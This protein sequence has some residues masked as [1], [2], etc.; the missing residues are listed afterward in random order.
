MT[1]ALVLQP[2]DAQ[3]MLRDSAVRWVADAV[4]ARSSAAQ[5]W[6]AMAELGWLG[7][8]VPEAHGGL[9]EGL[10]ELCIVAEALGRGP[11]P[12]PFGPVAVTAAG[13]LAEGGDAAQRARW[14]PA[15]AAGEARVAPAALEPAGA[16]AVR[17][18]REAGGWRLDGIK[19]PVPGGD[20]ADAWLVVA[21]AGPAAAGS[22][23]ADA[24]P[25]GEAAVFVVLPG[26][27]GVQA[28]PFATVDGA[29]AVELRLDAVRVPDDARLPNAD[30][31][32]IARLADRERVV[33]CAESVGAIDALLEATVAY[34]RTRVQFGRPLAANQALR[35]RLA[36]LAVAAEEAR[37]ITLGAVLALQGAAA[38]APRTVAGACAKVFGAARR[39]AE[40]A[41]Q[42]HGGMG[43]T[44]EL[45][46][47]AYLKRQLA[48]QACHGSAAAHLRRHA[49]GRPR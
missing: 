46:V 45:N 24:A 15:L 32:L 30:G 4:A 16:P 27:P 34:L 13:L 40:E 12:D 26:T 17:A 7:I 48:L 41:V 25:G 3:R 42:L 39:T 9:G 29:G 11:L 20:A 21:Q 49:A 19:R 47:A 2:D 23:V 6:R 38:D 22:S 1:A 5:R 36:D 43:V 44:D 33:A 31:A 28:A 35:H 14:L 37:S 10:R 18:H 8:A